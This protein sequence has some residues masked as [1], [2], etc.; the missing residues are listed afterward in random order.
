M[1]TDVEVLIVGA[2]FSG[3]GMAIQLDK[4][5]IRDFLILERDAEVG[6]TWWANQYPGCACDVE[7]H[8]YSF[9][10]ELNPSWSHVFARQ[11]EILAYL[12]HVADKYALR[13]RIRFGTAATSAIFDEREGTWEVTTQTGDTIRAR[14]LVS[15]AGGLSQP[16]TPDIPGLGSF[17]GA[18]FHSARWDHSLSLEGKR[19][20][21]IGT[22]ASAIQIVPEVAPKVASLT[23]FQRTPPWIVPRF[24]RVISPREKRLYAAAPALQWL[25]RAAYYWRRELLIGPAIIRRGRMTQL[26]ERLAR[27]HL[28]RSV[29]DPALRAKLLPS[30]VIGCKRILIS[31]DYYPAIQRD[32]VSLVTTPLDGVVPEGVR[33]KD[34]VTHAF[35]AIVLATGF[36]ASDQAVRFDVRG[37]GGR[38][39]REAWSGGMEAY[40]GTTVAGFPNLFMIPGPN[41]GG[42]HNS[43]VF[44]LEAQIHYALQ[45]IRILHGRRARYLDVRPGVQARY[46]AGLA[47]KFEDTV[48]ASGCRSWYQNKDGR[49]TV[50]LP[51]LTYPFYLRTRRFDEES[52]DVAAF[53][54]ARARKGNG[55]AVSAPRSP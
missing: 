11:P 23:V 52:Y 27:T 33:T 28:E 10:F 16:G 45:A 30:Y 36:D 19:V 26:L 18:M 39:L 9:S 38:L 15:C 47:R 20:G 34:G 1:T 6:G 41:I 8:L 43:L 7:S 24:D 37:L 48:W 17:Q 44:M 2:G 3:L 5:G 35:D 31:N 13:S 55:S 46:N 51:E 14:A 25:V 12:K 50:L 29:P 54:H 21:I 4:A 53:D 22:G 32:N 42:G 40:L 49:Q